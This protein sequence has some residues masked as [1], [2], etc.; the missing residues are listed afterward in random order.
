MAI[1]V[2]PVSIEPMR[3]ADLDAVSRIDKL[4]FPTPWLTSAYI[5]ELS[6]RSACYLVARQGQEV[7]GYAGQW[8]IMD[9]AHITT[10]AVDPAARGRKIGERLLL[11]LMEEAILQGASHSTLEVRE[12]NRAAQSLY[13]KYGFREA[14]LRKSYYTDNGE[15]ALVMWADEINTPAYQQRLRDLRQQVYAV[16]QERLRR[17]S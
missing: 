16:Y 11:A 3:R 1:I 17:E 2:D 15:N 7:V 6:N 4:C 12:G 10:L 9:E 8:V 5:T 14:A 13:R